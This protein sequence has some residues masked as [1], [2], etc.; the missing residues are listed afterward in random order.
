MSGVVLAA[1]IERFGIAGTFAISRGSK[2]E[3]VVVH[4]TLTCDGIAGHGECVPYARYGETPEGVLDTIL[5]LAPAIEA[6]LDRQ[7]LQ[8]A[9]PP[10]AARNGID[11]A[12]WDLEARLAGTSVAALTGLAVPPKVISAYTI[13]LDTPEAM[14]ESARRVS[15]YP[16]LKLKLDGAGDHERIAAVRAAVPNARLIVDANEAWAVQ[17]LAANI[18]ACRKL[19]VELVEQPLPADADTTLST[20]PHPVPICADESIH[21]LSS[22]AM[23]NSRY[24]AINIKLDK[25]GGLTEAIALAHAARA[26]GLRL[27]VG[28]MVGTSLSMA[29]AL[30]LCGLADWVDLDGPLLLQQDRPGGLSYAA[31]RIIGAGAEMWGG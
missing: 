3:A 7:G 5:G 11:C 29:P 8:A 26:R 15:D 25:T 2:H 23:L 9:L 17:D 21:G 1:A 31:G 4:V 20:V 19:G 12:F 27:M 6:G 10:G 30:L 22:L 14:A 24:E 16:L 13:S 18:E 28:C